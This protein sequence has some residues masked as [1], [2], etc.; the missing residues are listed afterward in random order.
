MFKTVDDQPEENMNG[1]RRDVMLVRAMAF[2]PAM[3]YSATNAGMETIAAGG[4]SWQF[5]DI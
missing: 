4:Y 1:R 3:I 2:P 5:A